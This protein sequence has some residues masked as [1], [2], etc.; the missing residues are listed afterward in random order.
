MFACHSDNTYIPMSPHSIN[1]IIQT[2]V[3]T[4]LSFITYTSY[5][6]FCVINIYG[7]VT[8]FVLFQYSTLRITSN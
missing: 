2:L 8:P 3:I 7:I 5:L 4:I 1:Y 6:L